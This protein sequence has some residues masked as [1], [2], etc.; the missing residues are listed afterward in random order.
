MPLAASQGNFNSRA[1]WGQKVRESR[2]GQ[3]ELWVRDFGGGAKMITWV[4]RA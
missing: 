1:E 3:L 2:N 4:I